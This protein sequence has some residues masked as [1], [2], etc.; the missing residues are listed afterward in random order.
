MGGAGWGWKNE[1]GEMIIFFFFLSL[2][3]LKLCIWTIYGIGKYKR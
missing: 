1:G 2:T 3:F